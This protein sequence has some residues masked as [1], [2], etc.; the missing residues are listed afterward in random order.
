MFFLTPQ[1]YKYNR[2]IISHNQ[3]MEQFYTN[4]NFI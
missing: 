1:N 4:L 2:A 3:P